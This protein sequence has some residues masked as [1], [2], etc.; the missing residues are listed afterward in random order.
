MLGTEDDRY[1]AVDSSRTT[2]YA[3]SLLTQSPIKTYFSDTEYDGAALQMVI[4]LPQV[5]RIS[6]ITIEPA[7]RYAPEL[8]GLEYFVD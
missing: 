3:A 4:E 8:I 7:G 6:R 1:K 2:A 5:R